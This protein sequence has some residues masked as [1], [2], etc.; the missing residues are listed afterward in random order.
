MNPSQNFRVVLTSRKYWQNLDLCGHDKPLFF[1]FNQAIVMNPRRE[2]FRQRAA[3]PAF[4]LIELLVVIAIIAI[5]AAMLLPALASAKERGRRAV[6]LS[7]LR[8]IGV[9]ATIY[10]GDNNDLVF[11]AYPNGGNA[12]VALALNIPTASVSASVGLNA[13]QTNG[14]CVWMCPS[15]S[16]ASQ[17]A[18][19]SVH[20]AWN[21]FYQYYGGISYWENNGVYSGPSYSPVKLSQAR[22][23]WALCADDTA[24]GTDAYSANPQSK[25]DINVPVFEMPHQR[26]GAQ[27]PDGANEVFCDGS[28]NWHKLETLLFL[29]SWE[30]QKPLYIYQS[31][32]PALGAGGPFGGGAWPVATP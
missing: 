21:I 19:D 14:A 6:C 17:P 15:L 23:A 12:F 28:A 22:P 18:F 4:T 8:Q 16:A 13:Q 31:D 9:G 7:N 25:W 3:R 26:H 5:L 27:C 10:A 29:S 2:F 24:T 20:S 1:G 32:L 30:T 11:T